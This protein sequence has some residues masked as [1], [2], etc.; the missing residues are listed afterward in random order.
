MLARSSALLWMGEAVTTTL[1]VVPWICAAAGAVT[2]MAATPA[3]KMERSISKLQIENARRKACVVAAAKPHEKE[4]CL[5]VRWCAALPGEG[6]REYAGQQ[7]QGGKDD[8][9]RALACRYRKGG[10]RDEGAGMDEFLAQPATAQIH[11]I[12]GFDRCGDIVDC[13]SDCRW[14]VQRMNMALDREAL[15]EESQQREQRHISPGGRLFHDKADGA[16]RALSSAGYCA[17]EIMR[18]AR[19][20][21]P[22]RIPVHGPRRREWRN[23]DGGS[24]FQHLT[25]HG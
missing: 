25:P 14:L 4:R 9:S 21:Q 12:D 13:R 22:D 15:Q 20:A 19:L 10:R 2:A 11:R 18:I 5:V 8:S 7:G 3:M 24:G 17:C 16:G 6:R 1:S 23:A